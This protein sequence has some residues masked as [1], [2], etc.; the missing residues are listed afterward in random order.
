MRSVLGVLALLTIVV[1][2]SI[3]AA[4]CP[5]GPKPPTGIEIKPTETEPAPVVAPGGAEKA[6]EGAAAA[7]E[8]K[9]EEGAEAAGEEKA[10]EG[11][12]AAGEEKAEEG[13]AEEST[14]EK[15][16]EKGTE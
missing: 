9:T 14:E 5:Q 1:A 7:G 6:E 3:L 4:G 12:E 16:E 11:A 10:E 8:E 2:V 13:A 15:A